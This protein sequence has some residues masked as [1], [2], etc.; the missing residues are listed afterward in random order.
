MVLVCNEV[1]SSAVEVMLCD[2]KLAMER[3]TG[4]QFRQIK[5]VRSSSMDDDESLAVWWS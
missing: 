3:E 5:L 1:Y 2:L 4:L